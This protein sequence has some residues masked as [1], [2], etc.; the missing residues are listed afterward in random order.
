LVGEDLDVDYVGK[1]QQKCCRDA[2]GEVEDPAVAQR[3][4]IDGAV[5][6]D[7]ELLSDAVGRVALHLSLRGR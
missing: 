3:G 2:F 5:T 6:A 7:A 4:S 1:L